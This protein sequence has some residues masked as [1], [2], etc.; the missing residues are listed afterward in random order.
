MTKV[1]MD[2]CLRRNDM[3]LGG[4]GYICGPG[5]VKNYAV[6]SSYEY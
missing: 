1:K 4:Y 5:F 6:A 2:S 3:E